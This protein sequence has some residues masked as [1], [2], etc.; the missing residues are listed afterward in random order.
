MS[1][2]PAAI[3]IRPT[4]LRRLAIWLNARLA[5]ILALAVFFDA[6]WVGYPLASRVLRGEHLSWFSEE[7]WRDIIRAVGLLDLPSV[8][9]SL[10]LLLM[11]FGL[12]ARARVAWAFSLILLIP[13][14]IISALRAENLYDPIIWYN[15]VLILALMRYWS[16][17]SRSSLAAGTLFALASFVSLIW[18]AMLGSLYLGKDFAPKIE[19]VATAAY[20]SVVA[21]ST[22]G[23]GDIVPITHTARLFVI[24]VVVVG[25]TVFATALGA[26]ITPLIGGKL[27][28]LIQRKTRHS[29][30]KNH[31]ILC[32]STPLATNLYKSLTAKGEAITVILKLNVNHEYP[33][34]ADIIW[35][36]ASG[37]ETLLEAG[38]MDAKVVLALRDDDPDNAFIVLAVKS[39]AGC[40]AKTVAV[41][42]ASQNLEKMR[43]VNADM[44]FSP[45]LLGAELLSR[46]LLGEKF[47]SSI[48]YELS[49][50]KSI[51][52]E[53]ADASGEPR[54]EQTLQT[55]P[56]A[57]TT[58]NKS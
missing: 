8:A 24:S 13:T 37:T 2:L 42:N 5:K 30:R 51:P 19:D 35:G 41:V 49:F 3:S 20:F 17:F 21:M 50:A 39:F 11:F 40:P 9:F 48:F 7:S 46:T 32:G 18:Y 26:V 52:V 22:V 56:S 29:M 14:T 57:S 43:R 47:D 38:V 55:Q 10:S 44:V 45:Q 27:R 33:P 28:E 53:P 15:V 4:L 58:T 34:N 6:F 23:F 36:D 1:D 25:I 16:I 54:V 31:L 12:W